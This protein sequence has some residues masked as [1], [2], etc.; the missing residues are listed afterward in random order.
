VLRPVHGTPARPGQLR[1]STIHAFKGLE[2]PAVIVTDLDR[3]VVPGF[4][5]LLYVGLTRATDR[6]T[7][8]IESETLRGLMGGSQ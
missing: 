6:L 3:H 7:A 2:A 4:E 8:V 5:S 1:H